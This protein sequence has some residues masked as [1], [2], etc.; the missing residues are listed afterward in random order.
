MT[1]PQIMCKF[2][3]HRSDPYSFI[4]DD[5]NKLVVVSSMNLVSLVMNIEAVYIGF[6]S[7][8]IFPSRLFL[9]YCMQIQRMQVPP[10]CHGGAAIKYL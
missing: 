6:S 5:E 8:C 1:L 4:V 3:K 7:S 10:N 9:R 2:S